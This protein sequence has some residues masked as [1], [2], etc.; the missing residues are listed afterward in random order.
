MVAISRLVI[1]VFEE[2]HSMIDYYLKC[3]ILLHL[4]FVTIIYIHHSKKL[5]T[6]ID[7]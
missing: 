6:I 1:H 7:T 4:L 2:A 3:G 5:P